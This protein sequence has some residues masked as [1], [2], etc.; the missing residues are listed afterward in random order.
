[1]G[2]IILSTICA[3]V[4]GTSAPVVQ[5][6]T[7]NRYIIDKSEVKNFDGSQLDGKTIVSY[8]VNTYPSEKGN[9][10]IRLHV[11]QTKDGEKILYFV[12][13]KGY[14]AEEFEAIK[15]KIMRKIKSMAIYK[16]IKEKGIVVTAENIEF[17]HKNDN[18]CIIVITT[19]E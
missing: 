8:T 10:V 18:D 15:P 1:M 11:I 16:G 4:L 13:N 17:V 12:D 9:D 6:D 19:K 5:P 14:T 2:T 3:I 7:L